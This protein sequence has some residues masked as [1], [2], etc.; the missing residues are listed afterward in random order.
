MM[1]ADTNGSYPVLKTEVL[2]FLHEQSVDGRIRAMV[3]DLVNQ[4]LRAQRVVLAN[5]EKEALLKDMLGEILREMLAEY[6]EK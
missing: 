4:A 2:R 1:N 5:T 6:G 3:L